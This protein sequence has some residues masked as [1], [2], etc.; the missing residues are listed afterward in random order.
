MEIRLVFLELFV[1][2]CRET[3]LQKYNAELLTITPRLRIYLCLYL[4]RILYVNYTYNRK[5]VL[6]Y[7]LSLLKTTAMA[8]F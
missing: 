2:T 1:R 8:Y 5:V 6:S 7:I 3:E 4:A